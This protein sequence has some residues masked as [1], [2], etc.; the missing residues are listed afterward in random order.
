[1]EGGEQLEKWTANLQVQAYDTDHMEDA[2]PN[3]KRKRFLNCE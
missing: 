2:D 1:M 3:L